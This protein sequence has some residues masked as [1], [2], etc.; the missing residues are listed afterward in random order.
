[1][2]ESEML[3]YCNEPQ[4]ELR[5]ELVIA[6]YARGDACLGVLDGD[7]LVGY[8]WLGYGATPHTD[9]VWVE[10]DP[11]ARYS[12]KKYVRPGYR[13]QRIAQALNAFADEPEFRR[14]RQFTLSFVGIENRA[15]Y[16]AAVRSGALTVGYA[17][18]LRWA[19]LTVPFRS[20]GARK[21]AFRFLRAESTGRGAID[22]RRAEGAS[23]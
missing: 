22:T 14:G 17:G 2:H 6:A 15:S 9:T 11:A 5:P 4:L 13:G 1:M 3:G 18:Y 19:G 16:K 23:V 12:Y 21:H 8:V 20:P 7:E 10:F